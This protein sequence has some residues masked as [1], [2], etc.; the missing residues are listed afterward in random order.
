L[1]EVVRDLTAWSLRKRLGPADKNTL[2]NTRERLYREWAIAAGVP[3][4]E[5]TKE[6]DAL[7]QIT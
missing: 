1:C 5:A 4:T 6:I 3:M 7:L 2:Q